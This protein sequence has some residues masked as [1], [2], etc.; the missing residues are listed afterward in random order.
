MKNVALG[1][2]WKARESER[3]MHSNWIFTGCSQ[4]WPYFRK[5]LNDKEKMRVLMRNDMPENGGRGGRKRGRNME[6]C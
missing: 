5:H 1:K 4:G 3:S 6:R 2:K